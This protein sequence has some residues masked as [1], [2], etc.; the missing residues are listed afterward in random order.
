MATI[1]EATPPQS[2]AEIRQWD[3]DFTN[4]LPS[5]VTLASVTATHIPPSGSAL[6]PTVG[7]IVG[8]TV[9]VTLGNLTV[10]GT[11]YLKIIGTLSNGNKS[12]VRLKIR[13]DY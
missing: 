2:E 3:I 6:T 5:G 9:P 1:I 7:A 11:H 10:T 13:C 8:A 4:D 12:E